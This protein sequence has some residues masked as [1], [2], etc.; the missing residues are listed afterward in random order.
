MLAKYLFELCKIPYQEKSM[1]AKTQRLYKQ[2]NRPTTHLLT[3]VQL[4]QKLYDLWK[5]YI[6]MEIV[7]HFSP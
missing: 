7:F 5:K 1:T 4:S 2:R 3:F 6:E